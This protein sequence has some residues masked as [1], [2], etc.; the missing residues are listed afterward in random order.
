MAEVQGRSGVGASWRATLPP[1]SGWHAVRS[2]FA[3]LWPPQTSPQVYEER[4]TLWRADSLAEAVAMAEEEATTYAD[5]GDG[6]PFTYLGLT[7]SYRLFDEP[8]DGA[9]VFSLMRDSALPAADYLGAFFDTGAER[10]HLL[11]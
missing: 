8:G 2:V 10:H 4:I 6:E 5:L 1:G 9:E 3:V 7:Q 11:D